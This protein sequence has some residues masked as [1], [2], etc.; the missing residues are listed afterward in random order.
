MV[1]DSITTKDECSRGIYR[2]MY[3]EHSTYSVKD[4]LERLVRH[5]PLSK[6]A[7]Q[8][9]NGTEFTNALL[10]T[11]SKHKTMF[12]KQALLDMGIAYLRI[13]ISTPDTMAR[14]SGSTGR[15]S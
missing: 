6:R 2:E 8:T 15:M 1:W 11:K 3:Q 9:D 7:I 10:V 14:L 5:S 12:I 13:Q 4:F